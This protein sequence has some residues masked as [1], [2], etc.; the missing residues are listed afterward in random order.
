MRRVVVAEDD[1]D[2]LEV[3]LTLLADAGYSVAGAADVFT[4]LAKV[5]TIRPDLVLLDYGLPAPRDGEEFLRRKAADLRIASIPVIVMSAYTL[6][7]TIAGTVGALRKP[8]ALAELL[9]M[10]EHAP[11]VGMCSGGAVA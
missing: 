4:A 3:L 6:S 9:A 10:V 2:T 7:L 11:F 5:L 1:R 8:F